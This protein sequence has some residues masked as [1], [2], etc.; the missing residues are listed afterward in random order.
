MSAMTASA[1][2]VSMSGDSSMDK[3]YSSKISA[4]ST[5]RLLL[6]CGCRQRQLDYL[7]VC[8]IL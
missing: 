7:V 4:L 1:Q 6:I 5:V 3:Y 8:F 2:P